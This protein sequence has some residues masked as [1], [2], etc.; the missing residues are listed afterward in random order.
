MLEDLDR[1]L[2]E[3][4]I[5][6]SFVYIEHFHTDAGLARRAQ[7]TAG[8]HLSEICREIGIPYYSLR[9][10]LGRCKE[11]FLPGDGHWTPEG[12]RRVAAFLDRSVLAPRAALA[13]RSDLGLAR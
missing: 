11:C 8:L 10:A 9:P 5:R 7:N 4:G 2:T 6:F 13:P 3:R 1:R 12:H